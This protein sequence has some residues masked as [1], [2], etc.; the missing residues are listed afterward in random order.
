MRNEAMIEQDKQQLQ[1]ILSGDEFRVY[2]KEGE[3][4]LDQLMTAF[5]DWLDQYLDMPELP[6]NS[7]NLISY[8]IILFVLVALLWLIIWL[9]RRL[10]H[11]YQMRKGI[12][13]PGEE[14]AGAV[15]YLQLARQQGER[16]NWNEGIR[17]AFLALLFYLQERGWIKVEK[18]KTNWEYCDEL[19]ARNH[20]WIPFFQA[21]ARQFER[22]WYG[23]RDADEA[24]FSQY[25]AEL[26][27]K[28]QGEVSH[29]RA[30]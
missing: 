2:Q 5:F 4:P 20:T 21:Q 6:A 24:V 25:M 7:G 9:A 16:G 14:S 23:R 10:F 22:V 11:S 19:K 18:W 26:E 13:L 8:A 27:R 28:L 15:D 12:M 3:N 1:E 17:Y 29:E 30:T